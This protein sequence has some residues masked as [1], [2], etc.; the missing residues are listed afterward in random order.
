[1]DWTPERPERSWKVEFLFDPEQPF[2]EPGGSYEVS[3]RAKDVVN[4]PVSIT[5]ERVIYY[6]FDI[7]E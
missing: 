6:L 7:V 1:V 5:H 4:A 2:F 3:W